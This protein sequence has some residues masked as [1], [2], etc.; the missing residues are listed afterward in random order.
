MVFKANINVRGLA[1]LWLVS[2]GLSFTLHAGEPGSAVVVIY[3]Q[4]LPE[5]RQ[6]ADYYAQKR[7]VPP[8]QVFGFDLPVGEAM[9][10]AE[11]LSNLQAPLLQHLTQ[12]HLLVFGP[13]PPNGEAKPKPGA[14][15]C[16]AAQIRYAA[17]CYGVP[18][19]ILPD[20]NL[21]EAEALNLPPE[22]RRNEASVDSQLACLP[23]VHLHQPWAGPLKNPAYAATNPAPLHPTNGLL[24]VT[25]LDGPSAAIARG[26]VD[27]ALEAETNGWWG[28]AY[29]DT[30]GLTNGDLKIGDTMLLETARTC[31]RLG[32]ETVVDENPPTF[33]AS[34]PM[35]Q[36]GIYAGWYDGTVSGPFTR[37]EVEFLPGAF[38]YHLHSFNAEVLRSTTAGWVGP[39]LAKG[40]TLTL[41]NVFEPYLAFTPEIST[42]CARL[43][44]S[45]FSFG[46]AAWA[47][48]CALSWQ[49]LA[50]GDPLYRPFNRPPNL[51]HAALEQRRSHWLEWSHLRV[52]NL[53][54]AVGTDPDDCIR[55]LEG[56]PLTRASAV[57]TEKLADLYWG[58]KRLT[59]ATDLLERVLKLGPSPQQ[60]IR[61]LLTLAQRRSLLGSDQAAF[62]YYQQLLKE[63]PDYPDPLAVWQKLLPVARRL[64]K[65]GEAAR[66][67]Q[68]IKRLT[69]PSPA[70]K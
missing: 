24:L 23:S 1:A 38:A 11:F 18:A 66:I 64:K 41:G 29:I 30:R 15:A 48:E 69:P 56:L 6:V 46:E 60:K 50:V 53:N 36:I 10:R 12:N 67:E 59:D 25:R 62:D 32:F 52:L 13:P 39:L 34:F 31:R 9:T 27:K 70:P 54:L 45:G 65:T 55:Y 58:K 42:F 2:C 57:L 5:S 33:P 4:R 14:Q 19:K 61:V 43:I 35:S 21:V 20:T 63:F 40:A 44:Y 49:T 26:L 3:N 16:V 17:L 28:R 68:E 7:Q 47:A 8:S 37:P 51:I 22:L